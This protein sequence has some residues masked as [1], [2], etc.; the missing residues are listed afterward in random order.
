[1]LQMQEKGFGEML[2]GLQIFH[3][4]GDARGEMMVAHRGLATF[5]LAAGLLQEAT[6]YY[7]L[8][9]QIGRK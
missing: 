8:A 5:F 9:F 4:L 3:E 2:Q 1:M 6:N 7:S